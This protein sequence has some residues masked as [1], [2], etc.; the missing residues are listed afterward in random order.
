MVIERFSRMA[1]PLIAPHQGGQDDNN[2]GAETPAHPRAPEALTVL[3]MRA[4]RRQP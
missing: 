4:Q 3:H 2:A 1:A